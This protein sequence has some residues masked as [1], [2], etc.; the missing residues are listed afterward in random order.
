MN[1]LDKEYYSGLSESHRP[2]L[3]PNGKVVKYIEDK[4][5]GYL[6]VKTDES[7]EPNI[8]ITHINNLKEYK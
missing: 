8:W 6:V 4:G 3:Q 5:N 1:K 7:V 2:D